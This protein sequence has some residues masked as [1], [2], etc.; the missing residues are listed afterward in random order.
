MGGQETAL[1]YK[2]YIFNTSTDLFFSW[3]GWPNVFPE[4]G[5]TMGS[6]VYVIQRT[7]PSLP[8]ETV[9]SIKF[10]VYVM[11]IVLLYTALCIW[12]RMFSSEKWLV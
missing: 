2:T 3:G 9:L 10:L 7:W 11:S 4:N 1:N 6:S 12:G 5:Q 8:L